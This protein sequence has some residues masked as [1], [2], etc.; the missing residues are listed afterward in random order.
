MKTLITLAILAASSAFALDIPSG[1]KIYKGAT[2]TA[3]EANG[4]RVVHESGVAFISYDEL[5]AELRAKYRQTP[6]ESSVQKDEEKA[7]AKQPV[8]LLAP[9]WAEKYRESE[10]VRAIE[11]ANKK[12]ERDQAEALV[13]LEKERQAKA[14]AEAA[15]ADAA[16]VAA[17]TATA[18]A[19]EKAADAAQ[20]A[21]VKAA[22][23]A[24]AA[25]K[26]SSAAS[27]SAQIVKWENVAIA[28]LGV[29]IALVVLIPVVR[30]ALWICNLVPSDSSTAIV[31]TQERTETPARYGV[32]DLAADTAVG[33]AKFTFKAAVLFVPFAFRTAGKILDRIFK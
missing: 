9:E 11:M 15:A 14:S 12:A 13:K 10:R 29:L 3:V 21:A 25:R 33:A 27:D 7:A 18:V 19:E 23:A 1:G 4:I 26:A 28:V 17:A 16:H 32:V 20:A 24:E 30:L 8:I 2:I 5:P 22:Q 31:T 6:T